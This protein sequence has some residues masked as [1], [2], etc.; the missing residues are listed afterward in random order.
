MDE[1]ANFYNNFASVYDM[2]MEKPH[3]KFYRERIKEILRSYITP[4]S[5]VLDIGCGTGFPSIFL[6]S[7]MT[8]TVYGIDVSERMIKKAKMNTPENLKTKLRFSVLSASQIDVLRE[9]GFDYVTS[10]Y[11]PL[12]YV[13]NLENVLRKI[14]KCLRRG[15][16][17]IASL[18]SKYSYPRLK[19]KKHL[20]ALIE[21]SQVYPHCIGDKE[22]RIRMY[23]IDDLTRIIKNYFSI[24]TF[25]GICFIPFL[26]SLENSEKLIENLN[27]YL[28]LEKA[29]AKKK[30]FVNLGMDILIVGRSY[31]KS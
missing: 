28:M 24:V 4:G 16:Y 26:L 29:L 13:S 7:E 22:V 27:Y 12:N 11:G 6:A 30:P 18:Y 10:T 8:C 21:G 25:E 19:D 14:Q 3:Q 15:G 31:E 1:I 5:K 2:L 9:K 23:D 20:K 17:L